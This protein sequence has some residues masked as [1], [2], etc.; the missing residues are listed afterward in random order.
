M[1]STLV[2]NHTV[3]KHIVPRC[4]NKSPGAKCAE[5][6]YSPYMS[7]T[8]CCTVLLAKEILHTRKRSKVTLAMC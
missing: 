4:S 5:I 3:Q 2:P 6:Q 1:V 8:R 7:L